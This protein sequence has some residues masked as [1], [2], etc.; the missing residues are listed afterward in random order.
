MRIG[1]VVI[2]GVGIILLAGILY[3]TITFLGSDDGIKE[4]VVPQMEFADM[5]LTNLTADRADM[6]MNMIIDNPAPVGLN[7]DSLYYTIFIE[8]HEVVKTTY[9]DSLQIEANQN[10]RIS[11]PLTIYYDKL[12][13]VLDQLEE[14]GRDSVVYTI[15]ATLFTDADLIPDDRINL[16]VE[17]RLP[18][19]RIPDVKVTDLSIE[20]ISFSGAVI[21][22][23]TYVI[24]RNVFSMGFEDMH[25]SLVLGEN[26]P[27]EGY[28]PEPL[29]IEAKDTA[30]I[31]MPVELDFGDMGRGLLDY[32]REGSDLPYNFS[33]RTKLVSDTHILEE[34]EM[35][36]QVTGTLDELGDVVEGQLNDE[37]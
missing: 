33:L 28:K 20:D 17:K 31:Q 7:I 9:P 10:T 35:N 19:V 3:L 26:E 12:Q 16:E 14:E 30:F 13:S 8:G 34:S 24:N 21:Q 25:Y 1:K 4:Q 36:M 2:I 18:L 37:E 32:I 6:D 23:E 5:Q 15:D 27:M 11:L 29:T 22:I